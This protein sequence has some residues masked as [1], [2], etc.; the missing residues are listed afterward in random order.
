MLNMSKIGVG[1]V[2]GS[3]EPIFTVLNTSNICYSKNY[4]SPYVKFNTR[5]KAGFARHPFGKSEI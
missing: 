4:F 2:V 1:T 5:S 3:Y